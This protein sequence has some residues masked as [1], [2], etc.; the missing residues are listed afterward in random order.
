MCA[1]LLLMCVGRFGL[2]FNP[3][4]NFFYTSHVH[5]YFHAYIIL[6]S[7]FELCY[8]CV[9][10]FLLPL[11]LRI[12]CAWHPSIN[13]LQLKILFVV[14]GLLVLLILSLLFLSGFVVRRP[15]RISWRTSSNAVFIWNAK[16]FCRICSTLL[17]AVSFRLEDGNLFVRYSR[18]VPSCIFKSFTPIYKVS[19][20]LCLDSPWCFEVHVLWSLQILY[21][22]CYTYLG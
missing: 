3:W 14:L 13:L 22:R 12:N 1:W 20:P 9:L 10:S 19:I 2:G 18:G 17:Y 21:L 4:C 15:V 8:D 6:F 5:A 11:F 16:S 7:F